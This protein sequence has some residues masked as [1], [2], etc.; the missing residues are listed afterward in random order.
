MDLRFTT[1]LNRIKSLNAKIQKLLF[2]NNNGGGAKD[3]P[4]LL[5]KSKKAVI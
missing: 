3:V 5:L 4:P 1:I 2:N